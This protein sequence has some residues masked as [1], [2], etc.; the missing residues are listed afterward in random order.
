MFDG[1]NV[2][3]AGESLHGLLKQYEQAIAALEPSGYAPQVILETLLVRDR[4]QSLLK[5][6]TL[7]APGLVHLDQLDAQLQTHENSFSK[8]SDLGRWRE[9]SQPQSDAWWWYPTTK[10]AKQQNRYDWLWNGLSI[11]F[12]TVSASLILNTASR[13][14]S[15][16]IAS[17]GT[18]AVAAQSVLTLIVGKGALTDSGRKAWEQILKRRGVPEY[19]WQEWSCGAAGGVFLA[20]AGIH[21]SMPLFA[22]WYN[23]WGLKDY[24][25]DR[26]ASALQNYQVALNL[27]PDYGEAYYNLGV[28][29]EDLQQQGDAIEAYQFVVEKGPEVVELQ[30]WLEANNNL[31][32]L[33]ILQEDYRAAVTLLLQG[34][35]EV[36]SNATAIDSDLAKVHYNLLKNL[37]WARLEQERYAEA[38]TSLDESILVL[39]ENLS[40][41]ESVRNRGSAYCLMAQALDAQELSDEA[42]GF[43][44]TCLI[45]ANAGNPDEDTWLG[46]Y[47]QRIQAEEAEDIGG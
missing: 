41:D 4:I 27:N 5:D 10:D 14:W 13:F 30:T 8:A 9:L 37:G 29:Y 23:G 40:N 15:G 1:D 3:E 43:W 11:V 38:E 18:L 39:E 33:Y 45:A 19:H 25:N 6:G 26:L 32:R 31:G 47:E 21:G 24:E 36:Q 7:N 12:L 16:G 35:D 46:V 17:A 20:V 28:L 44:E 2:T 22:T 42:E 34:S